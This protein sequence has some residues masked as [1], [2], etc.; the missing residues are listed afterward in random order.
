VTMSKGRQVA[1]F[2]E[3]GPPI[4]IRELMFQGRPQP[5]PGTMLSQKA[6]AARCR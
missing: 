4:A 3:N 1:A 5:A 2:V 6:W